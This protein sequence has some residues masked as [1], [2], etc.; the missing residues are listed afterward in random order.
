MK[1]PPA[2]RAEVLALLDI[3]DGG[4][5]PLESRLKAIKRLEFI[6]D[7]D[8]LN[9]KEFKRIR[10]EYAKGDKNESK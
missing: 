6:L 2:D 7:R 4:E 8:I 10:D 9:T 1:K 5:A 3:I